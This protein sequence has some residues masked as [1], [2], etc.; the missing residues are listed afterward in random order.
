MNIALNQLMSGHNQKTVYTAIGFAVLAT[1]IWSGNFIV[2]RG[3]V[4]QIPPISLAF[5]RWLTASVIIFPFAIRS[6]KN[7]IAVTKKHIPYLFWTSLTGIALFNT[8]VYV[9]G[10]YSSAINLAL[11]GT[12]Q[13]MSTLR[14]ALLYLPQSSGP[15]TS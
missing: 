12:T 5:F 4:S 14:L 9:A 15:A 11:I 8:L 1:I 3:V 7:E 2:A 10:H 6:F 13:K